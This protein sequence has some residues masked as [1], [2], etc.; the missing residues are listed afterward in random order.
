MSKE[1]K[2]RKDRKNGEKRKEERG[3]VRQNEET[4][5]SVNRLYNEMRKLNRNLEKMGNSTTQNSSNLSNILGNLDLTKII[6]IL[7]L[8]NNFRN[9]NQGQ[10][11]QS[12]PN[13]IQQMLP[14]L[15]TGSKNTDSN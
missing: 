1:D 5:V 12:L 10:E 7:T 4:D 2:K 14:L 13:M 9:L 3:A 6:G 11:T 15:D 8:I